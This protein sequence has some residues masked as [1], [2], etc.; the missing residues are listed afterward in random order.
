MNIVDDINNAINYIEAN[1]CEEL[2][3]D[4][5]AQQAHLSAFHFQ[6]VFHIACGYSLGQYIRWRRLTLAGEEL[7]KNNAKVIDIALK[8]GY[9]SPDSFTKAFCK[10]HGFLPSC[11]NTVGNNLL[12]FEKLSLDFCIKDGYSMKC[13]IELKPQISLIGHGKFICFDKADIDEKFELTKQHW[14]DSR[15]E[16]T[17]MKKCFAHNQTRIWYD[18]YSDFSENGFCH[19][20][21]VED[22]QFVNSDKFER[23]SVESGL[24][25]VFKTSCCESP[26]SEWK[27]IM[28]TALLEWLPNTDYVLSE[29]PQI[30][31]VIYSNDITKRCMEIWV[32]VEKA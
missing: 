24:Y 12:K 5:I 26:E 17:Q 14:L 30:N 16:Q 21:A 19:Y 1:I 10:F 25:A 6:R 23:V 18:V 11:V 7:K 22:N 29:R 13:V 9:E 15:E 20:I 32:P 3:F 4:L 27:S 31:R 2:A 28:Q 8:Y